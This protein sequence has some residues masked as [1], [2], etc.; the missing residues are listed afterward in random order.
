MPNML[1]VITL[2]LYFIIV[3][4][5]VTIYFLKQMKILVKTQFLHVFDQFCF[6]LKLKLEM[7]SNFSNF[8]YPSFLKIVQLLRELTLNRK[9]RISY[10]PQITHIISNLQI[11]KMLTQT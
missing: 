4:K 10:R 9:I 8:F 1:R 6:N 2:F 3:P 7:G 11:L 5:K